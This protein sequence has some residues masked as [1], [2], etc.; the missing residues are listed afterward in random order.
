MWLEK[1]IFGSAWDVDEHIKDAQEGKS[2]KQ[3]KRAP[4]FCHLSKVCQIS[5]C[6]ESISNK[7]HA[8]LT[9]DDRGYIRCS[10]SYLGCLTPW[11]WWIRLTWFC[12]TPPN[13]RTQR[14]PIPKLLVAFLEQSCTSCELNKSQGFLF[15]LDSIKQK[16]NFTPCIGRVSYSSLVFQC[17]LFPYRTTHSLFCCTLW[18]HERRCMMEN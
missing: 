3:P 15:L 5:T 18:A 2:N 4:K 10:T 9:K 17:P 12:W 11:T 7:D 13:R 1:N 6:L 16:L 8:Q 14:N